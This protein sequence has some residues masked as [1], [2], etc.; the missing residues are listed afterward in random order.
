MAEDQK[1]VRSE[2][3]LSKAGL[4]ALFFGSAIALV[5]RNFCSRE[6]A[7]SLSDWLSNHEQRKNYSYSDA[8][9]QLYQS[10]TDRIGMPFS[11]LYEALLNPHIDQQQIDEIGCNFAKSSEAHMNSFASQC[12]PFTPPILR[13]QL[14]LDA[15]WPSGAKIATFRGLNP[16]VGLARIMDAKTRLPTESDPH[17]DW[18]PPAIESLDRQFSAIV[19]LEMPLSGGELEIW[20]VPVEDVIRILQSYG[21]L[22]RE[23]LPEPIRVKPEIGDLIIIDTRKPH[24]ICSFEKGRRIVQTC[25]IGA[26]GDEPLVLWS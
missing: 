8:N 24:A 13:V 9:G 6:L 25:F 19:Y 20:H 10:D 22:K 7:A 17:L 4:D 2:K 11:Q 21:R 18:L 26:K 16:C 14:L 15:I 23:Y 1:L 12:M 5:V 3:N